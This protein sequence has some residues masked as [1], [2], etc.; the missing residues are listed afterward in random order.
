MKPLKILL[1][2]TTLLGISLSVQ[3]LSADDTV[4]EI[5]AD[6]TLTLSVPADWKQQQ[7]SS[8]LRLAQ[9]AIPPAEGDEEPGEL[10]VFPPFGGSVAQNVER[11]LNQFHREDRKV[12]M[13]KGTAKQGKYVLVDL[14]GTYNKPDGPPFLQRTKPTPGYRVVN[15]MLTPEGGGNY[16]LKITGPEKTIAKSVEAFRKSFGADAAQEE[17]FQLE[18]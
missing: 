1:S 14:S 7:P 9:F 10:V 5:K 4:R 11:W 17:E 12:K 18:Q 6:D 2:L 15:V 3:P 13:T 8:N 16:F